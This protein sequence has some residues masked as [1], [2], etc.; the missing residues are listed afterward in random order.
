MA[1][2][3]NEAEV[4]AMLKKKIDEGQLLFMPNFNFTCSTSESEGPSL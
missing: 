3:M 2:R 1:K 4:T